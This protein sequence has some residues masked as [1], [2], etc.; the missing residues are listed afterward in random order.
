MSAH[1]TLGDVSFTASSYTLTRLPCCYAC[2]EFCR[3]PLREPFQKGWIAREALDGSNR[4][5]TPAQR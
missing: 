4:E 5:A 3:L 1:G 2:S